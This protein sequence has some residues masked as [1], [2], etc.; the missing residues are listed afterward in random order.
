[1]EVRC[2][3]RDSSW[4]VLSRQNSKPGL[5]LNIHF[6]CA[7][8]Q[9]TGEYD[10]IWQIGMLQIHS[11]KFQQEYLEANGKK[12]LCTKTCGMQQKQG[13]SKI[14]IALN[15]YI[16]EKNLMKINKFLV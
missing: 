8:T 10:T 3:I 14:L 12:M 2:E 9:D 16:R 1:M 7:H 6:F 4:D 5:S 11:D 13:L 15:I